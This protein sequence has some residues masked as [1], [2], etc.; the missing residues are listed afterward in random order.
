LYGE[1]GLAF[2]AASISIETLRDR[3]RGSSLGK[4][5][6]GVTRRV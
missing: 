2:C 6:D 1:R 3:D 5:R 4:V